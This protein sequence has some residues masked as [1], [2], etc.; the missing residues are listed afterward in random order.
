M[1]RSEAEIDADIKQNAIEFIED[2]RTN[3]FEDDTKAQSDLIKVEIFFKL[4]SDE[5]IAAHIV[6]HVLPFA[7]QIEKRKV[8]FFAKRKNEIFGGI[9]D[10]AK[11]D[12]YANKFVLPERKGGLKDDD[13]EISFRY[14]DTFIALAQQKKKDK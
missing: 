6:K 4:M 8:K 14:F 1:D 12:Y 3:A 5:Q 11:I 2:L 9:G 10:Q 7:D 13:K